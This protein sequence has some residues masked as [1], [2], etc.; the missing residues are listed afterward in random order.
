M[1]LLGRHP[2]F[3]CGVDALFERFQSV[4]R[5]VF[6]H[7]RLAVHFKAR[8]NVRLGR[9]CDQYGAREPSLSKR[10]RTHPYA[11]FFLTPP[12]S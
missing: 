7:W 10:S 1:D 11:P 2:G 8:A 6:M 9:K 12:A 5:M 3:I 4:V